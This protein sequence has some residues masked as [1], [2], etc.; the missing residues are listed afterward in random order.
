MSRTDASPLVFTWSQFGPYHMDRCEAI[1]QAL[2]GGREVIGIEIVSDGEIYDWAPS[3]E[4]QTFRKLTLFPGRRLSQVSMVRQFA[5]LLRACLRTR[6]K[7]IFLCDYHL[8]QT[9]LAA[10]LL[11]LCGRRVIVMQDSKFDDK[12]RTLWR[13]LG[14]VLLYAPYNA[15]FVGGSRSRNYLEFLGVPEGRIV[16]GYDTV[17]LQ[18]MMRLAGAAP[19][20]QGM[21]HAE[22]HFTVIAR[23]VAQKNLELAIDA[24]AAYRQQRPQD[25]RELRLCGAGPLEAELRHRV[26]RLGVDGVRFCGWLDETAVAQMLSSSLAL[27]LPSIEEPFG[28][29]VNEAIALGVPVLVAENCGARDVLV[30]NAVNGYVIEPDNVAGLAHF[31]AELAG[32]PAEWRRLAE[33]T[34]SFRSLADTDAFVAG[35]EELLSR[36]DRRRRRR[37]ARPSN[38]SDTSPARARSARARGR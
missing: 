28:L 9:F 34:K 30:R 17:S 26:A 1:A 20:P 12:P 14:K 23:F 5:A 24:Y 3:G 15:A 31:M 2:P 7:H 25:G 10:L 21:A 6:A 29:V 32:N 18:R 27:I 13:E 38:V 36:L 16:V 4:G 11:R 8:P 35:V 37:D 19:A 22:R 33:N